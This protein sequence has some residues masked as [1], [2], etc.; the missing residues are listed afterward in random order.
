MS[1][2]LRDLRKQPVNIP[3]LGTE[4]GVYDA[5]GED[6]DADP[7]RVAPSDGEEEVG[8]IPATRITPETINSIVGRIGEGLASVIDSPALTWSMPAKTRTSIPAFEGMGNGLFCGP[9]VVPAQYNTVYGGEAIVAVNATGL[10]MTMDGW[11]WV[12]MGALGFG[13][14]ATAIAA[15]VLDTDP[16]TVRLVAFSLEGGDD[17]FR[18]SDDFGVNWSAGGA[19]PSAVAAGNL[20]MGAFGGRMLLA[21]EGQIFF[22]DDVEAGTWS[23]AIDPSGYWTTGEPQAFAATATEALIAIDGTPSIIRTADGFTWAAANSG[24]DADLTIIQIVWS[25][26]HGL[27]IALDNSGKIWTAP[28]GAASW[29]DRGTISHSLGTGDAMGTIFTLAVHGRTIVV[30]HAEAL[31]ASRDFTRWA[32]LIPVAEDSAGEAWWPWILPFNGALWAAHRTTKTSG[33]GVTFEHSLSGVLAPELARV[34]PW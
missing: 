23:D 21:A 20:V 3:I 11:G 28:A 34:V 29:A 32:R 19:A 30:S 1:D 22:S 9:L 18:Y 24:L 7:V 25:E 13:V 15:V 12:L 31:W 16:E 33:S 6:W 4:D 2:L 27:W 14:Q 8:F 26:S 5:P 17:E 10:Y